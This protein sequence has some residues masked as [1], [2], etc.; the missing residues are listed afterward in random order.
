MTTALKD[1]LVTRIIVL[2]QRIVQK[3]M[4]IAA[5]GIFTAI[6]PFRPRRKEKAMEKNYEEE[7]I[8][9]CD[10]QIG[11]EFAPKNIRKEWI[12]GAVEFAR[13]SGLV[14]GDVANEIFEKYRAM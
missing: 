7:L 8:K 9:Y 10:Q 4:V 12:F 1:G 5:E 14:A 3:N 2:Y 6:C 11:F 13:R